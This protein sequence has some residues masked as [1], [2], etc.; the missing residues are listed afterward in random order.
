MAVTAAAADGRVRRW[1]AGDVV[2][3]GE[4]G[5]ETHAGVCGG[6]SGCSRGEHA[7]PPV[8]VAALGVAEA[9]AVR[10]GQVRDL[11]DEHGVG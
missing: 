5:L 3:E 9:A 10:F 6:R 1:G 7:A 4:R 8:K 11:G 2:C